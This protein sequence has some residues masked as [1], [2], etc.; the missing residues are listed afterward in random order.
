MPLDYSKLTQF[1][2][3]LSYKEQEENRKNY[4]INEINAR[5]EKANIK[6]A[7]I[8]NLFFENRIQN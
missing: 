7:E 6:Q 1:N 2:Y 4:I 3:G 8:D 5:I